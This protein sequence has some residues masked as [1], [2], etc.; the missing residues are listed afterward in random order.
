MAYKTSELTGARLDQA[1]AKACG[2]LYDAAIHDAVVVSLTSGATHVASGECRIIVDRAGKP[3]T[4]QTAWAAGHEAS[5]ATCAF[6]PSSDW[7]HG[8]P[9]IERERITVVPNQGAAEEGFEA[10]IDARGEGPYVVGKPVQE[11]ETYLVAAMRAFV[12]A[13]IGEEVDL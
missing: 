10:M 4:P 6:C 8:G 9:I 2:Y 7:A 5:V 3:F 13:K 12:D 11:G 1:V